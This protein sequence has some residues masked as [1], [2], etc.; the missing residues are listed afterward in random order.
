MTSSRGPR[1]TRGHRPMR[2]LLGALLLIPIVLE[3]GSSAL[4]TERADGNAKPMNVLFVIS[5]DLRA[6]LGSY[7]GRAQTPNL[8]RLAAQGVRF[9][10]AY[11]QYPLC[12]PSRSSML[13]G[14]RP[15]TTNVYGNREWY[16][17]DHPQ[18]TSLP[19][20]F[21]DHGYTT[22]RSGKIFHEGI[23]DT[24][25][26]VEGGEPRRFGERPAGDAAPQAVS[27]SEAAEHVERMTQTDRSRASQSDRWE[28]VEDEGAAALADTGVADRAIAQLQAHAKDKAPLFLACGFSKPHSPLVAPKRFFDLY[29]AKAIT[30]PPDFAGRP[31]VP[32]GFPVGSIR[33]NNADLFI[34]REA[35]PEAA[36]EMIRAYL[37]AVSYMDWNVGR[38]LAELERHGLRER[39]IVV[40]WGDH[41]YQLGEKGKW[42]KAGSLWEWGTRTPL[43]IYDP[44]SKANGQSSAR[45]VQALDLYPTLVDLAGLPPARGLEGASLRPLLNKP[46]SR[47][48]RPA[49]SLWNEHGRGIT[50][51]VVRTERWRYAE[52]FG[53]GAGAM[54]TDPIGDPHE[55]KNVVGDP[56]NAA[57]VAE[58]SR[59]A[60]AYVAGKTEA[61]V[62]AAR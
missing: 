15:T 14:R 8:D 58:L 6:E 4:A 50:G 32:E 52:F 19:R 10:R 61:S 26:W 33:K 25:A 39:T 27:S 23:D 54:L 62:P 45:I 16:G 51:V 31:T 5:D 55:L 35:T 12:N 44:R 41:G 13:T 11:A 9:E 48:N 59:L 36:Q 3:L 30:L 38:V 22:L 42:S 20:Y 24:D 29:D 2:R 40:F 60:R 53:P 34:A 46:A 7:G 57:V 21:R 37:A 1:S 43:L 28:A 18:W 47:W 56:A 17:V 49:F